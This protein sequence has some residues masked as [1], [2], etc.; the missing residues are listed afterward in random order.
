MKQYALARNLAMTSVGLGLAELLAPRHVAR[1]IGVGEQHARILQ[2]LGIREIA[3]GLGI[4]QGNPKHFLWGRV[5]GDVMDLALLAA[6]RTSEG[7][8]P[9]R[10]NGAIAAVAGITALD[11]LA[12]A[13]H[14]REYGEA[15]WRDERPMESRGGLGGEAPRALPA[16]ADNNSGPSYQASDAQYD[17]SGDV[18]SAPSACELTPG[19][20]SADR[21]G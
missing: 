12:A 14:S 7:S 17:G 10:I 4:L 5:A 13:L 1:F 9:R 8:N 6:A 18:T 11:V 19:M 16:A 20:P 2:A 3:S 21:A 15:Q